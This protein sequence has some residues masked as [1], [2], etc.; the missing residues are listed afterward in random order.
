MSKKHQLTDD[1]LHGLL[2]GTLNDQGICLKCGHRQS[3]VE[4]DA[5]N[6][7]CDDCGSHEVYG[8]EEA[9]TMGR[10]E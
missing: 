9:L 1:E 4:P 8:M 5:R 2:N 3:G 6:Y 7:T 10:I